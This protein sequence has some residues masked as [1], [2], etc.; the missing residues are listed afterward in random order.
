[1]QVNSDMIIELSKN[2]A[3]SRNDNFQRAY[4]NGDSGYDTHNNAENNDGVTEHD[5]S[6]GHV[7]LLLMERE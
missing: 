6:A 4:C 2:A 3:Q 7:M 5:E 1:M